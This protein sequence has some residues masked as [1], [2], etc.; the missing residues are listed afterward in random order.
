MKPHD[1]YEET[2]FGLAIVAEIVGASGWE[3]DVC[4]TVMGSPRFEITRL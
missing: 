4:D 2:G 1:H 3:I